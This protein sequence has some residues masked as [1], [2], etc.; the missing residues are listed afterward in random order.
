MALGEVH[1]LVIRA[2][3][4]IAAQQV[5]YDGLIYL[6]GNGMLDIC[7]EYSNVARGAATVRSSVAD[8]R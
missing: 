4:G 8:G 5:G 6:R 3:R 1:P 7:G 2:A